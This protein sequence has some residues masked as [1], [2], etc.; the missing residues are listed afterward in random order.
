[1]VLIMHAST[2]LHGEWGGP[3]RYV[4]IIV[5]ETIPELQAAARAYNPYDYSGF[6]NA[7]ACFHTPVFRE[8][9]VDGEWVGVVDNHYGGLIR[10][11]RE[12]INLEVVTHECVHA[13]AEIWRLDVQPSL[14]IGKFCGPR[15]ESFAYMVGDLT[16]AV[17]AKIYEEILIH[18]D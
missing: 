1:M 4:R 10:L 7:A 14:A 13:A 2:T 17:Y 3:K 6:K 8:K 15:E 11:A 18:D 12:Y 16:M 5:H 9:C